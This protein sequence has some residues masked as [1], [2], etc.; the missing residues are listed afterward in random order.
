MVYLPFIFLIASGLVS[1]VN[2]ALLI[3]SR[4]LKRNGSYAHISTVPAAAQILA[5]L[6]LLLS[7][8]TVIPIALFF[9]VAASD[10]SL[11]I[12]VS[13]LFSLVLRRSNGKA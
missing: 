7:S 10:A 5:M 9:V 12:V 13:K 2:W 11:Y 4:R 6:S 3:E 8:S 1:A